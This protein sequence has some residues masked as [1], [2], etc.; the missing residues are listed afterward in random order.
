MRYTPAEWDGEI[1]VNAYRAAFEFGADGRY[2]L[3]VEVEGPCPACHHPSVDGHPLFRLDGFGPGG[4]GSAAHRAYLA[5]LDELLHEGEL[6]EVT[7]HEADLLCKCEEP[8][9]GQP[10]AGSG[11][12]ASWS[13]T[14]EVPR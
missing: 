4:R 6:E 10:G 8:H 13:L 2:A 1:D 11:C 9:E 12:G 5:E 3:E 14:V 7:V